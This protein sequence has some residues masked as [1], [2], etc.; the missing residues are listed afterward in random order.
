MP[1]FAFVLR[2]TMPFVILLFCSLFPHAVSAQSEE[3]T[4]LLP[5]SFRWL[6]PP[7][8]PALEAAWVLGSEQKPDPISF[9]QDWALEERFRRTHIPMNEIAPS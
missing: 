1:E 4:P 9:A 3:P 2:I 7:N 5:S 6:S 8:N